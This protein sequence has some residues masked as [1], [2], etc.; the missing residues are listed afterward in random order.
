MT[1]YVVDGSG[2]RDFA[3]FVEQC[4]AA[5]IRE[6]GG[7]W[8]G[9]LDAFNDYLSWPTPSPYRLV[10]LHA[11]AIRE[12]LGHAEH[13]RH[14]EKVLAR[15]HPSNRRRISHELETAR[16]GTGP[17]LFDVIG[18]IITGNSEWVELC[19]R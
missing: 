11:E 10:L 15:C 17:T 4:N 2:V 18:E 19:L 5:F 1:E 14:L 7:E 16:A 6:V 8:N 9:N 12:A 3:G 13:A